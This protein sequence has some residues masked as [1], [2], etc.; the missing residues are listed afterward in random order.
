ML[1]FARGTDDG[2]VDR[3]GGRNPSGGECCLDG[4]GDSAE[5]DLRLPVGAVPGVQARGGNQQAHSPCVVD[6]AAV[7]LESFQSFRRERYHLLTLTYHRTKMSTYVILPSHASPPG[8]EDTT[9]PQGT[10]HPACRLLWPFVCAARWMQF[11]DDINSCTLIVFS[12][13]RQ[14]SM[15]LILLQSTTHPS[16]C[17]CKYFVFAPPATGMAS[18]GN[19]AV[20][21]SNH[22]VSYKY[23]TQV[24]AFY[25]A[26]RFFGKREWWSR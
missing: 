23:E 5:G 26:L 21:Q 4:K 9:L 18:V 2:R 8:L 13:T 1:D 19:D 17:T 16:L 24:T 3:S 15:P 6:R 7:H 12:V 22:C 11:G 25:F 10:Q 20:K 14:V